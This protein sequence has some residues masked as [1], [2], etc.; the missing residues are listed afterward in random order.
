MTYSKDEQN[1]QRKASRRAVISGAVTSTIIAFFITFYVI[2][3]T[4]TQQGTNNGFCRCLS[5]FVIF[6]SS[7]GGLAGSIGVKTRHITSGAVLSAIVF[8]IYGL[9]FASTF[10]QN[11][12][13]PLLFIPLFSCASAVIGAICGGIGNMFGRTCREFEG[14]RFWP[15]FSMAELMIFV[16]LI[17]VLMSCLVTLRQIL[18]KTL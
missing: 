7:L 3:Y 13:V 5:V 9:I 6:F 18:G 12:T 10:T 2:H 11:N 17:A 4:T 15:Q 14:N 1:I 16:F 8:C